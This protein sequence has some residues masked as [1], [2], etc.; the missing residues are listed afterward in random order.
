MKPR[1]VL[2]LA[3][4]VLSCTPQRTQAPQAKVATAA[5]ARPADAALP[6][7]PDISSELMGYLVVSDAERLLRQLA[8]KGPADTHVL[9]LQVAAAL[10]LDPL[11]ERA[12]DWK[13]PAAIGLINPAL[14]ARGSVRPYVAMLPI[15]DRAQLERA[16]MSRGAKLEQ[17]PWGFV[18]PT[19]RG[20]LYVGFQEGY[21][22]VAWRQDLLAPAARQLAPRLRGKLD[23]PIV[24]H[25]AVDN[26][27]AAFGPQVDLV[28]A[29][30]AQVANAG[31]S[32]AD[33]QVAFALRGVKQL[34][35]YLD[36]VSALELL[37]NLDSGGLTV[38]A[39]LDG[40]RDGAFTGFVLDQQ[41][42]PAWGTQF[43]PR[44]SVMV[45]S[46]HASPRARAADL[47]ASLAYLADAMPAKRP[48]A[49]QLERW[50][51][52]LERAALTTGGE[53][54]YA[55][56][57]GRSGGVGVGG[58]Y[59][60]TDPGM[61]RAA[62]MQVYDELA[63]QLGALVV[64]SLLLDPSKFAARF[65]MHK[66]AARVAGMEVD[67]VEL[68]AKWPDGALAE[69]RLFETLFGTRLTL[70]TAFVGEQALFA[71]GADWAPRLEA[72]INTVTGERAAS[73]GDEADFAEALQYRP[74]SRVSLSYLETGRMA[75]FAAGLLA[76]AHE[77]DASQRAA[78]QQLLG[79][80]GRGA[81]VTTTNAFG[82]RYEVT[83]HV[84]QSAIM[85]TARLNGALWRVAL[86]P[87]VNPP[88]MPPMPIPPPHVAPALEPVAPEPPSL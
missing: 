82:R 4:L 64:R 13:R 42:G 9:E 53:L 48:D 65:S 87:L 67:L 55:V 30:V 84:P 45:Y 49:V 56:W 47:E 83:T 54:A 32:T 26:L 37:L 79:Q 77:L 19:T 66:K 23:A 8:P 74:G 80:V 15:A 46:T 78:L 17:K 11:V 10:G 28:L 6:P 35:H 85:G 59:R 69:R 52:T 36:S 62:V 70:A 57:P 22:V 71:L 18:L 86:S 61:A 5:Q 21:A 58:A 43:L 29:H 40:K 20:T 68:S 31:G 41:P 38:T 12:L 7:G 72:M 60:V 33:P 3:P 14:L 25:V 39:R 34:T 51:K 24:V 88:M 76:Q 1:V 50:K 81:I 44:D 2:L 75:R 16:L 73:L 27:Y 63:G